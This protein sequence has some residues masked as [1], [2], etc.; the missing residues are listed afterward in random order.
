V[1]SVEFH[2][3]AQNEFIAAARFYERQTEG[4]G[5]DF[6]TSVQ[7]AYERLREFPLSGAPFVVDS[8]DF[9]FR[10]FRMASC[11]ASNRSASTSSRSC[12]FTGGHVIDGLDSERALQEVGAGARP[13][14]CSPTTT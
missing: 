10:S 3:E 5:L 2:P 4:L 11:I 13:R 14:W 7:R 8:D 12:T 1:R 9:L 6:I